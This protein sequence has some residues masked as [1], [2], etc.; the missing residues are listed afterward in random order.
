MTETKDAE[1]A[2][3]KMLKMSKRTKVKEKA[4]PKTEDAPGADEVAIL[5]KL[6]TL[7][8]FYFSEYC[9][10]NNLDGFHLLF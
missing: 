9:F 3:R 8:C 2:E 1:E 4:A 6:L 7:F 10:G 5:N